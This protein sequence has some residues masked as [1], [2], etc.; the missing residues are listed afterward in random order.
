MKNLL[1]IAITAFSISANAQFTVWE[2]DFNDSN[3]SDWTVWDFNAVHSW[4]ACKD[5]QMNGSGQPDITIGQHSILGV[6]AI[7]MTTGMPLGNGDGTGYNFD[8]E[9]VVTPAVDLSFYT[10]STNLVINAQPAIY[11]GNLNLY[12]Y[13]STS[14]ERESFTVIDTL[15]LERSG[16]ST[17][18]AFKDYTVDISA[19][20]GK[21]QVYFALVTINTNFVGYEIDNV[22]ITATEVVAGVEDIN[23]RTTK[24][25]QN[26]VA[27]TL[28]LQ[29]GDAAL[30]SDNLN[31][32]IYNISGVLVIDS[33][34]SDAGIQVNTLT[35]GVYFVELSG[36]NVVEKLKFIKK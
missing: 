28:Q 32:K 31:I 15:V 34:Y 16:G 21:E 5:L 22:K 36:D 30:N 9:W 13:A 4:M 3:I 18:L 17:N 23:K 8:H 6:Y 35:N 24:I 26:P 29:L 20:N 19:F 1:L 11:D 33:Q 25:Q 27:E 2:D 12:V 7:D 10:G 14:L